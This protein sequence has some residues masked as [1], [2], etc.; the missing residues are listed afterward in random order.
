MNLSKAVNKCMKINS[1]FT[2]NGRNTYNPT[3]K[4]NLSPDKVKSIA[5]FVVS[6]GHNAFGKVGM[7][8]SDNINT[9]EKKLITVAIG[10]LT[11]P[12]IDL[13]TAREE[14][15]V[16]SAI[17]TTS[18]LIAGGI[19]GVSIRAA[20]LMLSKFIIIDKHEK[21]LLKKIQTALRPYDYREADVLVEITDA[22]IENNVAIRKKIGAYSNTVGNILAVLVMIGLTNAHI[23]APVT[24]YLRKF[25]T[26]VVK[27][28][29]TITKSIADT[30]EMREQDKKNKKAAPTNDNF[31]KNIKVK[32]SKLFSRGKK[33]AK[34]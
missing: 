10:L 5:D 20:C 16:D 18:K 6:E 32:L 33:E 31:I 11:Q 2:T 17:K 26:G 22:M 29:K 34:S 7:W 1:S 13:Y 14:N 15:K 19:T 30:Y 25:F 28:G 8:F 3:F 9:P 21:D 23:D 12:L 4:A 27:E 24:T